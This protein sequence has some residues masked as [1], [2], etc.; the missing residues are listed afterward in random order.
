MFL[1]S[2]SPPAGLVWL[3]GPGAGKELLTPTGRERLLEGHGEAASSHPEKPGAVPA[4]GK[5]VL[6]MTSSSLCK[7]RDNL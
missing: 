7:L 4:Q 2:S 1:R 5:V 6:H 3:P